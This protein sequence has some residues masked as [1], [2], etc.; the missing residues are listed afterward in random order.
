MT[1]LVIR[2]PL[3]PT[4]TNPDNLISDEPHTLPARQIRALAPD[5]GAFYTES[6]V[7]TDTSNNQVLVKGVQYNAAELYEVPTGMFGKE[8]CAILLITDPSVS[9][10]VKI[11]YQAIGGEYSR[12]AQAIIQQIENLS[13]DDRPVQWGSIID[14]PS[15]YPPSHH[16]HDLGDIYGFEYMVHALDR[17]RAAIEMGDAAS[18]DTI[19]QYIDARDN[20]IIGMIQGNTDALAAHIADQSNPH[21]V[22]KT[23]VQLGSVENYPIASLSEAQAGVATNRYMTPFLTKAAIEGLIPVATDL[24][25]GKVALNL[26]A[27]ANDDNNNSDALTTAG[28]NYMLTMVPDNGVKA[29]VMTLLQARTYLTKAQA[30]SYYHPLLGYTPVQQGT[31]VGQLNNLVKIGWTGSR[32]AITVDNTNLGVLATDSTGDN[33]WVLR[34]GDINVG[35]LTSAPIN[36]AMSSGNGSNG[37]FIARSSGGG[38]GGMAGMTFWND[39][40]AI[41][42]GVRNDGYFGLGGFSRSNWSWYSDSGGNMVAAGNVSAY[43]DPLLKENVRPILNATESLKQLDGVYFN[44]KH[45]IPHIDCKAGKLD[46]G[47]LA[48]QVEKVFP[49]IVSKSIPVDN[50]QYRVVAYDKLV[51]VLIESVKE[52]SARIDMLEGRQAA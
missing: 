7:V 11:T 36:M 33:R 23:Q 43:S 32:L 52:L 12:S 8:V 37:S 22:N 3:D 45:G 30:D 10:T 29:A 6:I 2:Y 24:V 28:L 27:T 14:K 26:G 4:G 50:V 19:Y 21:Q 49:E 38:D 18:H 9:N 25:Q 44:W 15:E 40:Y 39:S 34:S 17:I 1:P 41:R 31:G 48:D 5:N 13:L 51:A 16:L 35:Q 42:L 46:L 47:I 20:V